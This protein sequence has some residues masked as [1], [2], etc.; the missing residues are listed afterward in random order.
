MPYAIAIAIANAAQ[1]IPTGCAYVGFELSGKIDKVRMDAY[2][3]GRVTSS[4]A[5]QC[6]VP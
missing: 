3:Y 5:R 2:D 6:F 4:D 1:G